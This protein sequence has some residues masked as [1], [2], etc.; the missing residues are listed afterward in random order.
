MELFARDI[1]LENLEQ[2]DLRAAEDYLRMRA[3]KLDSGDA[4][5]RAMGEL[6]WVLLCREKL[7]LTPSE[8]ELCRRNLATLR[9]RAERENKGALLPAL[10]GHLTERWHWF[11]ADCA[12]ET[13]DPEA[14]FRA[15]DR[16]AAKLFA[17]ALLTDPRNP[18]AVALSYPRNP[19]GKRNLPKDVKAALME[20]LSGESTIEYYLKNEIC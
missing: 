17:K 14:A 19:D 8:I 15:A 13:D 2:T 18:L 20:S 5:A 4:L 7:E 9:S 3:E 10:A 16:R 12:V 6:F 11:F 1:Y